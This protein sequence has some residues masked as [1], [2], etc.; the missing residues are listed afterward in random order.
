M[1][2]GA[3]KER[4]QFHNV[5]II[6]TAEEG[7]AIGRCEDGRIIQVKGAVPGDIVDAIA[8]EK[9][10]GMY[11]TKATDFSR[12]S[13]DRTEPFCSHFGL[14][15]GC[16][17]QHMAYEAQLR[18]KAKRVR[19]AFQRI[20]ELDPSII[21]PIVG[22][23]G[24][25][26]YRNKLE[27]TAS[28]RRWLTDEEMKSEDILQKDGIGFHLPGAFD[29]VLDIQHCY[30]QADPSN[31]IR[32]F[33]KQLSIEQGW[34]FF[35]LRLKTGFVRN[36]IV[37]NTNA[38]DVMVVLV[39]G[40]ANHD[41]IKILVDKI[42]AQF[43]RVVSIYSCINL[44]VNDSIHDLAAEHQYGSE[45]IIEQL[46]H[47]RFHI[48]PKSFFQTN[49]VQA[50]NLYALT[51]QLA[52]LKPDDHVYDLYCGVGSL[53]I[54]MADSCKQVVGIEIIAEAI[55][56]AGKNAELNK[57][58]NTSFV[59]GQV[60]L[61]MDPTFVQRYGKPDVVITDPPRAGMHP[62]V[63]K[64]LLAAAPQR[65]VYVSCNPATQ[66][67]DLKMLSEL[68]TVITAIPVDMFPHTHHIECVALLEKK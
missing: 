63:I 3:K 30:L 15:G 5:D 24:Q 50:A 27:F 23:P 61:L 40:E 32:L 52:A 39:V 9:R 14:C 10:K 31:E 53:G 18:Y 43:P 2:R 42:A 55:V 13:E 49:S 38:G 7:L 22:A 51:K 35:N 62:D 8:L 34:P 17:W 57:L 37:R 36:V 45:T 19:D 59:V 65:I 60:E 26:Y 6:D 11:I 48:G 44:K 56:D 46:D 20:G 12:L 67:R 47:V 4:K 16:K 41:W 28:D 1:H 21:Q 29:K 33:I 64:H 54:Y 68:Y 58:S 25:Q 66:A